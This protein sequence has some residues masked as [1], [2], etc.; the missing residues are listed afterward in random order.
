M[1]IIRQSLLQ[2]LVAWLLHVSGFD[3]AFAGAPWLHDSVAQDRVMPHGKRG[4][5]IHMAFHKKTA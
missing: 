1:G 2:P 5:C 3:T 4:S